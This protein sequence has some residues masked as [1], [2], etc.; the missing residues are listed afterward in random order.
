M[1]LK[2]F[3]KQYK[4]LPWIKEY[5]EEVIK[6]YDMN[7]VFEKVKEKNLLDIPNDMKE[8]FGNTYIQKKAELEEI[9]DEIFIERKRGDD[10]ICI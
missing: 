10:E 9:Y 3:I 5:I 2:S 7:V 1:D 6:N 8:Y 4:N